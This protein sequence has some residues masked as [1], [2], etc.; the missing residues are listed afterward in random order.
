MPQ[1]FS[2]IFLAINNREKA[3]ILWFILLVVV[4]CFNTKIRNSIRHL[5]TAFFQ[6][7]LVQIY[8]AMAM[9]I[10]SITFFFHTIGLWEVENLPTT[11]KWSFLVAFVML[12]K[13]DK[14]SSPDYFRSSLRDNIKI[15]VIIEFIVNF[16]VFNIWV[17]LLSFPFMVMLSLMLAISETDNQYEPAKKL[18]N[19][20]L[21]T[22]GISLII[23]AGLKISSNPNA[24]FT[25]KNFENFYHPIF[26]SLAFIP[27]VYLVALYSNYE[28]L[29]IRLSFFVEEK[30]VLR[31][32]KYKSFFAIKFSIKNLNSWSRYINSN[33]RFKSKQEVDDAILVFTESIK[34]QKNA[35]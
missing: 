27:F 17:E 26:Y 5:I 35:T 30:S 8:F 13:F 10:A 3:I 24:F 31:Y 11:L 7:K 2:D 19:G 29:F 34:R 6:K 15:L 25:F 23:Y 21:I 12:F 33:W 14:A 1:V 22:I 4:V 9:Y 18:F 28:T 16:Y 20:I 32:A